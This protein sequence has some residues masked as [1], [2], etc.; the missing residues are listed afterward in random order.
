VGYFGDL[1][2]ALK[3]REILRWAIFLVAVMTIV[4]SYMVYYTYENTN[5]EISMIEYQIEPSEQLTPKELSIPASAQKV[6][7]GM[8]VERIKSIN[9]KDNIFSVDFYI[10]FKW[11]GNKDPGNFQVI[12][13]KIDKKELITNSTKG[14]QKSA[15]YKVSATVSDNSEFFRF[16]EDDQFLLID[17]QDKKYGRQELVYVADD[18]NSGT[19]PNVVIPGYDVLGLRVVEKPFS[20]DTTMGN[21]IEEDT[22]FS[23]FS[24]GMFFIRE[25]LSVLF[26]S[27]I[28]SFAAVFA[29]LLSLTIPYMNRYTMSVSALFV[30]IV[31]M[32]F[33]T[34]LVPSGVI[35][36]A[37]IINAFGLIVIILTLFESIAYHRFERKGKKKDK[38]Q[39]LELSKMHDKVSLPILVIGYVLTVS[40]VI[41]ISWFNPLY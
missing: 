22:T 26:I 28:G 16:P 24:G 9:L 40:A 2:D 7:T 29:A 17:I 36:V 25:D 4:G 37:H 35:T 11:T 39:Y 23:Q 12:N 20:Y 14:N 1:K 19:G 34:N 31:N 18:E 32:V 3:Y 6:F 33:I 13:G 5:Q 10:W 8:Y 27:L 21:N 30:G 38:K 15:L 41:T